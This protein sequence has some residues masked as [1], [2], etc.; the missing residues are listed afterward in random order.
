MKL[1]TLGTSHGA[2]E[3]G[4]ACSG[5]LLFAGGSYYLFDCGADIESKLMNMDIDP[6]DVRAIFI[7]HM[8]AD[9]VGSL[10]GMTKRFA[11]QYNV[12]GNVARVFLPEKEAVAPYLARLEAMHFWLDNIERFDMREA[13]PG[14]IYSDECITVTAIGT[15]HIMGGKYPSFAYMVE[16]EGKRFLYT[17]DLACDFSDYPE[18]VYEKDFDLILS[19]LVHFS[20]DKNLDAIIK[21]RTKMMVFTHVGLQKIPQIEAAAP[22]IP[23]CT[24]VAN[25]GDCFEF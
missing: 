14:V 15:R 18:V 11:H 10:V 24:V 25:D 16:G 4:R 9:H 7:S 5:S 13:Q 1:Y 21:S 20:V 23:F 6:S 22:C 8:H 3:K 19:E 2:A 12:K 17:G